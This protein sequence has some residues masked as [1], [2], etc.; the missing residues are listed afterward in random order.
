MLKAESKLRRL[1]GQ[2]RNFRTQNASRSRRPPKDRQ[3]LEC[4]R[5]SAAFP[6]A[7]RRRQNRRAGGIQKKNKKGC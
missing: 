6:C 7:G 4:V 3:V 1:E 2:K 5:A